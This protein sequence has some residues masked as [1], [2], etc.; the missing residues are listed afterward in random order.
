MQ[1][2]TRYLQRDNGHSRLLNVV[3]L[4]RETN[5][6]V[7]PLV[8]ELEVARVEAAHG[9][10]RLT[11]VR[12]EEL[13]VNTVGVTCAE[14]CLVR[15]HLGPPFAFLQRCGKHWIRHFRKDWSESSSLA[16]SKIGSVFKNE[17]RT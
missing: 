9:K 4:T 14:V 8:P 12:L 3:D 11:A 6:P 15:F 5:W 13:C 16:F 7:P 10:A 2:N 1:A 17:M